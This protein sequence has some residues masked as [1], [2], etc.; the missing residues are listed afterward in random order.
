M[1]FVM[2][3]TK[4]CESYNHILWCEYMHEVPY[5]KPNTKSPNVIKFLF[6]IHLLILNLYFFF[7]DE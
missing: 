2:S 3:K 1:V 7:Q 4:I 6:L 5:H